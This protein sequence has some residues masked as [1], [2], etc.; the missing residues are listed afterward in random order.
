MPISSGDKLG[1]YEIV[2]P[3]GAGGMGEVYRAHDSRMGR[4]VAIKVSAERFNERFERE[5]HAVAA[6]NHPNV[7]TIHD[8]GPNYLVMELIEGPTLADR[9]HEGPIPL[10]EALDIARQIA[11]A[12]EAAHEKG[13][14]HRDLKPQ[15]IKLRPD[16]SVKVLDFGLAKMG[17]TAEPATRPASADSPTFTMAATQVGAILGTAA[18]M[19]PEQARGKVV[20]RR[21]DI[22]AF[23][24]VL[25]EMITGKELFAGD[26]L[27]DVLAKVV[28]H[29]PDWKLVPARVQPLLRRCLEKDPKRR[30]RHIGD[31]MLLLDAAPPAQPTSQRRRV[32]IAL[33]AALFLAVLSVA[34]TLT[35]LKRPPATHTVRFQIG[36][37][38][39]VTFTQSAVFSMSPDGQK[40]AFAGLGADGVGRIWV[41]Q[42][43]SLIANPVPGA[44][45]GRNA[46]PFFWSPDS[47][48]L[49]FEAN[50]KLKRVD[51]NGGPVQD[52]CDAPDVAGGSWNPDDV[53]IFGTGRGIQRVPASG[54][55]PTPVTAL[56]SGEF[57][58]V[59]PVFLPDGHHFL[60]L[61]GGPLGKRSISAGS[62]DR[63]PQQQDARALLKNDYAVTYDPATSRLLFVNGDMVL[64]Q[65]FDAKRL[66]FAG[67][68][69]PVIEHVAIS[70]NAGLAY[71]SSSVNGSFAYHSAVQRALELTWLNRQGQVTGTAGEPAPVAIVKLAPDGNRAI[72]S[73][74]DQGRN[75]SSLWLDDLVH[76]TSSRFTFDSSFIN[77][78]PV[79]SA[80]GTQIA[81]VSNRGDMSAIYKKAANGSGAEELVHKFEGKA[82]VNLT[83]WSH[84]SRFLI[85][86]DKGDVFALPVAGGPERQPFPIVQTPA[87]EFAGYLSPDSR[88]IAY[89]SNESGRNEIYVQGVNLDAP[90]K[91]SGKWLVSRGTLGLA[92]WRADGKELVYASADGSIMAVDIMPGSVFQFSAPHVLFK[93]P[94]VFLSIAA[95]PG[96]LADVARDHQRFLL[97][98]PQ[99]DS[100][101]QGLT[102]VLNAA[103]GDR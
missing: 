43:D 99:L 16:G 7:C 81:W 54:G 61:R 49:A 83:D 78:Q 30:L 18:Y 35:F 88:W 42:L 40:I 6:L 71:F 91:A 94:L 3:L 70:E 12:L 102:V 50:R 86:S 69:V 58:H 84:D 89:L 79:W 33:A 72:V 21:T 53:I 96:T 4:D 74:I 64:A 45:I 67:E 1:P 47:R 22:W 31:A 44:E 11:D 17:D 2:K 19:S 57:S 76:G 27:T 75:S 82:L 5:V 92:R 98:M 14:I 73:Q 10:D 28:I 36:L 9:I 13:I 90:G 52:I 103:A 97:A 68:P 20:D 87:N 66:T 59:F 93:L 56:A 24:V 32:W 26:T 15:N 101:A 46:L 8:V 34:A 85:F 29:E 77:A 48:Y 62:I 23:G 38:P 41:R 51:M 37:P 63:K 60:Y 95:N 25:Y 80:D 100:A 65:P 55:T 39:N